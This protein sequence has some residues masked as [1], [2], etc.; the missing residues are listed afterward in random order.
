MQS[1][2]ILRGFRTKSKRTIRL[3]LWL[4]VSLL[5]AIFYRQTTELVWVI[6]PLLTLAALEL[7]RSIEV[8]PEERVEVG[9]VVTAIMI[10]LIYIWFNISKIAVNPYAQ[11]PAVMPIFGRSSKSALLIMYGAS[12]ILIRMYCDGGVWLVAAHCKAWDCLGLYDL[13][14]LLQPRHSLGC[15][16][17]KNPGR[18]GIMDSRLQSLYMRIC[19]SPA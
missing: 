15:Q 14:Q 7:S 4:G 2:S 18:S 5:L 11:I 9:V 12:A 16:R 6:I 8:Q 3:S 13:S 10:L 17:I 1:L 19:C